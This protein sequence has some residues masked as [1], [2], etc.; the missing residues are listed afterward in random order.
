METLSNPAN[1][2]QYKRLQGQNATLG[3]FTVAVSQHVSEN[4]SGS[5][6]RGF[7]WTKTTY[8]VLVRML[9]CTKYYH[10]RKFSM[11]N[12]VTWHD[13]IKDAKKSKG[14]IKL[15]VYKSQ[16]FAFDSIQKINREYEGPSYRW[17]P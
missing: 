8:G 1:K 17:K 2:E 4:R 9:K 14:K 12:G 7:K 5:W 15:D 10:P 13:T 11:D 3:K 6:E 16:E